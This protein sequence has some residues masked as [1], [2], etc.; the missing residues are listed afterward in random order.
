[1]TCAVTPSQ[2]SAAL[3][4]MTP[5]QMAAYV[6]ALPSATDAQRGMVTLAL[7]SNYPEPTNDTEAVTPAHLAAAIAAIPAGATASA[8]TDTVAGLVSLA[9]AANYPSASNVEATTPAYV[10]AAVAAAAPAVTAAAAY[11]STSDTTG[12]TPAYVAAAVAAVPMATD[13][14][15]GK[16][17]LAV[18]ANSPSTSNTEATTPAYVTAATHAEFDP[19][20]RKPAATLATLQPRVTAGGGLRIADGVYGLTTPLLVD[21]SAVGFP[22]P[23]VASARA[24]IV[25]D[26]QGNTVL[27]QLTV[28]SDGIY[29]LGRPDAIQQGVHGLDRIAD[30]TL[31]SAAGGGKGIRIEHKAYTAVENATVTGFAYGLWANCVLSSKFENLYLTGNTTAA[32]VDYVGGAL[33]PN[34]NVFQSCRFSDSTQAGLIVNSSG[35]TNDVI[36]GSTENNGSTGLANGGGMFIN[37]T[38]ANGTATWNI[39]SHYFEANGGVGDLVFTNTSANAITLNLTGCTFNR[40]LSTRFTTNNIKLI[41]TGGGSIKCVLTAC[42]FLS[43]GTYVP[44][45]ARPFLSFD[46]ACEIV[47]NGCT[48]SENVSRPTSTRFAMT[49]VTSGIVESTGANLSNPPPGVTVVRVSAGV[50]TLTSVRGWAGGTYGYAVAANAMGATTFARAIN[51]NANQFTVYTTNAAGAATD[52]R[53]SYMV[54]P[55]GT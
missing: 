31:V 41:N 5:T 49:S 27:R 15:A 19:L 17:T 30:M 22:A 44:S 32:V 9:I 38:G 8:A 1:M 13:T 14:V 46:D 25:G 10:A 51:N 28:N 20:I 18:A 48:F 2:L 34:A 12:A 6:A 54:A 21:Y 33:L 40:V 36:G 23:G 42:S 16:V 26:S 43:G 35:A 29:A 55:F 45:V 47:D 39:N 4:A 37:V 50:Y 7:A 53:F 52:E 24:D 3:A 11:P